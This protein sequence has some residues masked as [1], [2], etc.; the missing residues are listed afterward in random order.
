MGFVMPGATETAA[1]P[2]ISFICAEP[3]AAGSM[4]ILVRVFNST[5][6][7]PAIATRRCSPMPVR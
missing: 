1:S 7:P 6:G 3:P 2:E 4:E 5:D